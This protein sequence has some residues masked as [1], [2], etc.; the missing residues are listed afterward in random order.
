MT[1]HPA[2]ARYDSMTYRR[3]GR[4][5]LKLPAVSLGLWHNF[6]GD[7][8]FENMR[9][10][11]RTAFDLG[12]THFDLANNYGPPP[13]SAEENFG[14]LLK[15]DF[16]GHRDELIIS[17]K[18]GYLMWPGPY[19]EWGSRKYLLASLDQSLKRMGLDYVDIF[20]SH[21]VDPETPLEET[22]GALDTAVRQGKALYVGISSYSSARTAQAAK[23][24]RELGTP[25]VIHQP[26]YSMLNRWTESDKLLDRLEKE[27]IGCIA[28]SPL[29][30]GMPSGSRA[31]Q[32]KSLSKDFLS[33]E[34]VKRIGALNDIAKARGQSLAQMAIAWVLRDKR[35][36]SA[37]IG[38]SRPEQIR[39]IVG[40]LANTSFSKKELAD[41]DKH[42]KDSDIN[43]WKRSSTA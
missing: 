36:T 19:G 3:C 40:A 33:Q 2:P 21:R 41:I 20:Y 1:Y 25:C 35:M 39:E 10:M 9:A 30:Q 26:S 16:R 22:M 37:L 12:I 32:A 38:A 7:S 5:G 34:A 28:F 18:A 14:A 11:C 29:A 15:S 17:S 8:I 43:L 24:L 23:I 31:T 27:G 6:G 13:G 4:S 42:A